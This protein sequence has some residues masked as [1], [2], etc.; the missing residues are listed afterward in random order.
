M[1]SL[2]QARQ[3]ELAQLSAAEWDALWCEAKLNAG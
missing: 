2:A 1:E 3:L